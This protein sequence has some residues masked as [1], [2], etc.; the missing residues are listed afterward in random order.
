MQKLNNIKELMK[1]HKILMESLL[2]GHTWTFPLQNAGPSVT[3]P[4][5][6]LARFIY[7][8]TAGIQSFSWQLR[9]VQGC[10]SQPEAVKRQLAVMRERRNPLV[11]VARQK[12]L[13]CKGGEAVR[14]VGAKT[15]PSKHN[16]NNS[17]YIFIII[18][19]I[20]ITVKLLTL[21]REFLN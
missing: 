12:V 18:I 17:R 4:E 2:M 6:A 16:Y 5:T 15:Q 9:P 7:G 10:G 8:S 21:D 11:K 20:V 14:Q 1:W 13:A 3:Q 19:L